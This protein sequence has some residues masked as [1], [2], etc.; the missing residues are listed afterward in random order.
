MHVQGCRVQQFRDYHGP[1]AD[2]GPHAQAEIKKYRRWKRGY[3]LQKA[4]VKADKVQKEK[5]LPCLSCVLQRSRLCTAAGL[6][7]L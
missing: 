4:Q 3:D 2:G 6:V 7:G 5:V 1:A